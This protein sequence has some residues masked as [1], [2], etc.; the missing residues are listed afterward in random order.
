MFI[1]GLQK[2][3]LIDY[4]EK[5][6]AIVFTQGCNFR[7]PYCHNPELVKKELFNQ[8]I[9]EKEIFDFLENKKGKLDAVSITGGEPTL[10][11]DLYDFIKKVKEMDFKVKLDTNG[12]NFE[13][14]KKLIDEKLVDYIAMDI[15]APL[16][17]YEEVV[18]MKVNL[19][20]IKKSIELIINSDIESEFRTTIVKSLLNFEDFE[21]IGELVK[22]ASYYVVQKFVKSKAIDENVF[23]FEMY[24]D[25]GYE[26]IKNIMSKYVKRVETR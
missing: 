18:R 14:L 19:E 26:K 24:D 16:E 1:G 9:S 2:T 12:S 5:I 10:Q 17:K 8:N 3:S 21:K 7:C 22:G 11:I 23:N 20:N 25:E 6:A 4:P 13:V 15:K